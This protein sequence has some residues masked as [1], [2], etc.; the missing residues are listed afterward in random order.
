[1]NLQEALGGL[2]EFAALGGWHWSE[3]NGAEFAFLTGDPDDVCTC[4]DGLYVVR[5]HERGMIGKP[6]IVSADLDD[7]EK[8]LSYRYG[9]TVRRKV[10]LA[11]VW[12]PAA[13]RAEVG[14]EYGGYIFSGTPAEMIVS[15]MSSTGTRVVRLNFRSAGDWVQYAR[16]SAESIRGSFLDLEGSPLFDAK[17]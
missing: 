9:N 8:F 3:P 7:V 16:F 10:G 6:L 17:S 14:A 2:I 13:P 1:M 15:K 5:K 4:E 11:E 12:L